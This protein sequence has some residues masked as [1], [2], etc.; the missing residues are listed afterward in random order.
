MSLH[1]LTPF[2]LVGLLLV[3][4]LRLSVSIKSAESQLQLRNPAVESDGGPDCPFNLTQLE[5]DAL[6]DFFYAAGG[7]GW[8]WGL[9]RPDRT[10]WHFPALLSAPCVDQ[11]QGLTCIEVGGLCYISELVL[12]AYNLTGTLSASIGSFHRMDHIALNEN[13]IGGSL[14]SQLGNLLVCELLFLDSNLFT[15]PIPLTFAA[16]VKLKVLNVY[17]NYITGP[18]PTFL[19]QLNELVEFYIDSNQLTGSIPTEIGGLA[20]LSGLG[21]DANLFTGSVPAECGALSAI[22]KFYVNKNFLTGTLPSELCNM[23]T[24]H[25]LYVGPNY[26]SGSLP[27]LLTQLSNLV[28][29]DFEQNLLTGEL[30]SAVA[31]LSRLKQIYIFENS[32]NGSLPTEIGSL[33]NLLEFMAYTNRFTGTLPESWGSLANLGSLVLSFNLLRGTIPS[34]YGNLTVLNSFEVIGMSLTGCIPSSLFT[35]TALRYMTLNSNSFTGALP[36]EIK[37]MSKLQT[38]DVSSNELTGEIPSL[39]FSLPALKQVL[40][41]ENYFSGSISE[42]IVNWRASSD[43]AFGDN[44]FT[45]S[46]PPDIGELALLRSFTVEQ[47]YFT[48]L[49][50]SS[51]GDFVSQFVVAQNF[52]EGGL[53]VEYADIPA[54]QILNASSNLLTGPISNFFKNAS[55]LSTLL[56]FDLSSNSL[57]G[58]L[59]SEIF[60]ANQRKALQSVVL[61]SNCFTGSIPD[62]ICEAESLAVLILDSVSSAPACNFLLPPLIR[63]YFK[64]SIGRHL[65]EGGI[66]SCVWSMTSLTTLHLSGN[67]LTGSLVELSLGT[68]ALRDVSLASNQFTGTLP[69]SWQARPWFSL[70]LSGNKLNGMLKDDFTIAWNETGLDLTVNRFSGDVPSSFR[71]APNINVLD[72][73]LFACETDSKPMSDPSSDEYVCGSDDFDDALYFAASVIAVLVLLVVT[74]FRGFRRMYEEIRLSRT[75]LMSLENSS[76]ELNQYT[77]R[78]E[79]LSWTTCIVL[80]IC[81]IL[82]AAYIIMK[83]GTG[84]GI[85][86]THVRQYGWTTTSA[87]LHGSLPAVLVMI[88]LFASAVVI[89]FVNR[90][91]YRPVP[92]EVAGPCTCWQFSWKRLLH[93]VNVLALLFVHVAVTV[94]VNV[95]YVYFV[96]RGMS[97]SKLLALQF[98]LG[99]FKLGWNRYFISWCLAQTNLSKA[100]NLVLSSFMAMFTFIAGPFIANI[101]SDSTCF[102][103]LIT[104][105]PDVSSSFSV[106]QYLCYTYCDPLCVEVCEFTTPALDVY[107]SVEPSWQYSFQCSSSLLVNYVPVLLFSYSVSGLVMPVIIG[108]YYQS[109]PAFL[110]RLLPRYVVIKFVQNTIYA[111]RDAG[112]YSEVV[113]S[114][115]ASHGALFSGTRLITRLCLNIGVI[116]SFGLA[117]PLLAFIICIDSVV[118]G[119]LWTLLIGRFISLNSLYTKDL[120]S[121][122]RAAVEGVAGSVPSAISV[123]VCFAGLFWS[124]FIFDMLGDL[125]G[126]YTGGLAVLV[127]TVGLVVFLWLVGF[128]NDCLHARHPLPRNTMTDPLID[129]N[130]ELN[131]GFL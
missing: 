6:E 82:L 34:N 68:S 50:P 129:P 97:S 44:F 8:T 112:Y 104:G 100:Y 72:G 98:A 12:P 5:Y 18:L 117:C 73:N 52:F 61:Y 24:A 84:A 93:A 92:V 1:I 14:P 105:Q 23:T 35:L 126:K 31:T 47:N 28:I 57:T 78:L 89:C 108:V 106:D 85:W 124:I 95:F 94:S 7:D 42:S 65:L 55:K 69:S 79:Q 13:F 86:S 10:E 88:S 81:I 67:G 39:L 116:L 19:G 127:P 71:Y 75:A 56:Y 40:L 102:K 119:A 99:L 41:L 49:L 121:S 26:I 20:K 83:V 120:W 87:Y 76:I 36:G 15:G 74:S 90:I 114:R 2:S 63:P 45:G 33:S 58:S 122:I 130:S 11:W 66:P 29:M 60:T 27:S 70:D 110:D 111:Y 43:L 59:P 38:M 51:F 125:Y 37:N 123:T 16:L 115:L 91:H 53:P 107:T 103:Y 17:T 30:P 9:L 3:L 109:S 118:A 48:G 21:L 131:V 113:S 77:L 101:F 46:I 64:V 22:I 96:I 32:F 4:M 25:D 54:L 62:S 80:F 128:V